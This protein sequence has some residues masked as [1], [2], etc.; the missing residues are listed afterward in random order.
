MTLADIYTGRLRRPEGRQ[1]QGLAWS[2]DRDRTWHKY[3]DNPVP[4]LGLRDFRDPKVYRHAPS[5][6]RQR[7]RQPAPSA[8]VRFSPSAATPCWTAA[9]AACSRPAHASAPRRARRA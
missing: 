3:A 1:A 8:A 9:L 6:K 2:Q 4:D 7:Q 5:I